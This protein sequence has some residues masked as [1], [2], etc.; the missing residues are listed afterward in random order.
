MRPLTLHIETESKILHPH[1]RIL[2]KRKF[3]KKTTSQNDTF[4]LDKTIL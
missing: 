3:L 4:D 2:I 1:N